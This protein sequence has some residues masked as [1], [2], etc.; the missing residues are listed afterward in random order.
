MERPM[1]PKELQIGG[2]YGPDNPPLYAF[3]KK[4]QHAG[5]EVPFPLGDR[6]LFST[7]GFS[8]THEREAARPFHATE[9]EFLRALKRNPIHI[10]CNVYEDEKGKMHDGYL[11]ESASI[12]AGY[13]L[14]HN[15]P[16]VLLRPPTFAKT[17]P[18]AIKKLIEE[19]LSQITIERLDELSRDEL[20]E[21]LALEKD[22]R[23]DY[24]LTDEQKTELMKL[25]LN[26]ARSYREAWKKFQAETQK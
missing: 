11:G 9:I 21:F 6:V 14:A 13:A 18:E 17:A 15:K 20:I 2:K 12:E 24:G 8:V 1:P 4:L 10:V 22:K 16:L 7:H 25:V 23:V 3:K 26:L 5:I 19:K